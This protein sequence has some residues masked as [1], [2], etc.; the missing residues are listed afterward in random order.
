MNFLLFH[1]WLAPG[2]RS[3]RLRLEPSFSSAE[4]DIVDNN[5]NIVGWID[6][7]GKITKWKL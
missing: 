4:W 5:R 2:Y 1:L 6:P 3:G 7:D